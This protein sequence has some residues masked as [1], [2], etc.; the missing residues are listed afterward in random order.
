MMSQTKEKG[1][2]AELRQAFRLFDADDDGFIT[3]EDLKRVMRV[4]GESLSDKELKDMFTKADINKDSLVDM[5]GKV[6][7]FWKRYTQIGFRNRK[8]VFGHFSLWAGRHY[9]RSRL[10]VSPP[11]GRF[12]SSRE[13]VLPEVW[14]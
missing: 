2:Q 10:H 4:T 11:V 3:F 6:C 13:E 7:S 8:V 1:Q 9:K 5:K 14:N 12:E